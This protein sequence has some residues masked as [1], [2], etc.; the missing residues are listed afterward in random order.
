MKKTIILLAL[1]VL[2]AVNTAAQ[3]V[4]TQ[5]Q[6]KEH[7]HD[8][9]QDMLRDAANE[10]TL[11][12]FD[13]RWVDNSEADTIDMTHVKQMMVIVDKKRLAEFGD[14]V[15]KAYIIES[16][17]YDKNGPGTNDISVAVMSYKK[18]DEAIPEEQPFTMLN[19]PKFKDGY[20][21][22]FSK[23]VSSNVT[24]PEI[25]A[26]NDIQGRVIVSFK[27]QPDGTMTDIK[28][29]QTPDPVLSDEVLRVFAEA[30]AWTPAA[31]P[32]QRKTVQYTIPVMFKL[33]D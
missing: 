10:S 31:D 21:Q 32:E 20:V 30:P 14:W 7:T 3:N 19:W 4:K 6:T 28:V 16:V 13:G 12:L 1:P 23:Y 27:V 2:L 15:E 11:L 5:P 22:E 29:L 24:Y 25:A 9:R 26:Q 17:D 18:Q 8:I 33:Q